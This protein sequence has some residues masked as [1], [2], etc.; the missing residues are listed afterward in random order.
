MLGVSK[1]RV[2]QLAHHE[3]F[4]VPVA[5]LASGRIWNLE[6]VTG[7]ARMVREH[8]CLP[9][10]S[11]A[12][13]GGKSTIPCEICDRVWVWQGTAWKNSVPGLLDELGV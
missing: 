13:N 11:P 6:A 7:W 8:F 4:P 5:D 1:Q 3:D 12:N 9:K 10:G 2:V